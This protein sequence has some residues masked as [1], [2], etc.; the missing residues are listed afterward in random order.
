MSW[1]KRLNSMHNEF[2]ERFSKAKDDKQKLLALMSEIDQTQRNI[3]MRLAKLS[4]E[5]SDG[6]PTGRE[7]QSLIR[8]MTDK[9]SHLKT[10]REHIRS[11]LAELKANSKAYNFVRNDCKDDS[12]LHAF[13]AAAELT[14]DSEQLNIVIARASEIQ[15]STGL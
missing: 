11:R 2:L 14:L 1:L 4:S 7:R 13:Y 15:S 12:F 9:R 5:P 6:D 10:E 8:R 3:K